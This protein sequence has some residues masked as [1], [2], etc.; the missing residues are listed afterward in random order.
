MPNCRTHYNLNNT[1]THLH[2]DMIQ[3]VELGTLQ[4]REHTGPAYIISWLLMSWRRKVTC[5]KYRCDRS[6]IFETRAFWIFIE[7]RIRSKYASWD[8]RQ[9]VESRDADLVILDYSASVRSNPWIRLFLV[10]KYLYHA[11]VPRCCE[12]IIYQTRMMTV[13]L[14]SNFIIYHVTCTK[15]THTSQ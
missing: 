11:F 9:G 8:G 14:T 13:C 15:C 2:F 4:K 6:S 7:F 3:V 10:A 12:N 1:L 5:A